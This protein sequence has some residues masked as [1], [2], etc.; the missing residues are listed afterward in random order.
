MD[1]WRDGRSEGE[2]RKDKDC[3]PARR[4][5]DYVAIYR[6][7][8]T[9]IKLHPLTFLPTHLL[10]A[11]SSTQSPIPYPTHYNGGPPPHSKRVLTRCPT[12]LS[13]RHTQH[14]LY[15]S[16]HTVHALQDGRLNQ[17]TLPRTG[18]TGGLWCACCKD[19]RSSR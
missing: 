6:S 1:G 13:V 16:K 10:S 19:V 14:R 2:D 12:P 18:A 3:I 15:F 17:L 7:R 5:V 4:I 9:A 8:R 11:F